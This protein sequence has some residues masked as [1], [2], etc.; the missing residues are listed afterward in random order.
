MSA[1]VS[2]IM[3]GMNGSGV[4]VCF[5]F[6]L[7]SLSFFFFVVVNIYIFIFLII[8]FMFVERLKK[9]FS[10]LNNVSFQNL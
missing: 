3:S 9:R 2:F 8:L 5:V 6:F 10:G 1:C 7:L 4:F